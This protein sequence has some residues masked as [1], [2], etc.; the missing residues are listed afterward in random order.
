MRSVILTGVAMLALVI[1]L[2]ALPHHSTAN[3]DFTKSTTVSG[4]V[5]YFSFTNP[6]SFIDLQVPD[7]QGAQQAY[8]IFTVA[9]VVMMRSGW[10]VDD[11]KAG[12]KITITGNPDRNTPEF[13]YLTKIVFAS[14]K[15]WD[16][17]PALQR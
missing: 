11:L 17:D 2:P 14:G 10:A 6:H 8:K 16:R 3:F 5:Q 1:A 12:D 15:V 4:T 7:A 13:M 9:R